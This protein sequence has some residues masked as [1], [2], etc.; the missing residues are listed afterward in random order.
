MPTDYTVNAYY[1][2]SLSDDAGKEG[3]SVSTALVMFNDV[4]NDGFVTEAE[5]LLQGLSVKTM[6]DQS[7]LDLDGG[8]S[9][10]GWYVEIETGGEIHAYFVPTDGTV[11]SNDTLDA[12][13][14]L[15]GNQAGDVN[16]VDPVVPCFTQGTL[17][18]TKS[19]GVPVERICVGDRVLTRDNGFQKVR[20][21]GLR[22]ISSAYMHVFRKLRPVVIKKGSL[23]P[24]TPDTDLVVSP[25]HR[26]LLK[27]PSA[28]LLFGEHE[29]LVAAKH[30][31]M[32][33]G[34]H[35]MDPVDTDY[36]HI[37][38]EQHELIC[39]DGAWTESFYPGLHALKGFQQEQ[40]NELYALFPELRSQKNAAGFQSA[41]MVIKSDEL[42]VLG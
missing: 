17:I 7:I 18:A 13:I 39:S 16:D 14:D 23:G 10:T 11:P 30:L 40:R 27:D 1:L 21:V 3:S 34:V 32:R 6:K 22:A 15:Q 35:R 42:A 31:L 20:W 12:D 38:F 5:D 2:G 8:G 28:E 24:N 33:P 4:D 26:I 19:G 25:N 36:V 9:V 37:L 29:V 41:R